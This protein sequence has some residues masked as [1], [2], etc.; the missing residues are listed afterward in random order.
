MVI[1]IVGKY[2]W[3]P[4]IVG[5]LFFDNQDYLGLEFWYNQ[6]AEESREIEKIRKKK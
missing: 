2:R 3:S 4:D 6:V 1:S 5:D